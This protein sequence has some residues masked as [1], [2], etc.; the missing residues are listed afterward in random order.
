MLIFIICVSLISVVILAV[1]AWV[2]SFTWNRKPK[3]PDQVAALVTHAKEMPVSHMAHM[4]PQ[5]Q[6]GSVAGIP[7]APSPSDMMMMGGP[8]P[9]PPYRDPGMDMDMQDSKQTPDKV[10]GTR[11][12]GHTSRPLPPIFTPGQTQHN[13]PVY[14]PTPPQ[15]PPS[16]AMGPDNTGGGR[17]PGGRLPPLRGA[18]GGQGRRGSIGSTV[19]DANNARQQRR[20][21]NAS[22][23]Y[24]QQADPLDG[25]AQLVAGSSGANPRGGYGGGG[26]SPAELL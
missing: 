12:A 14:N 15:G 16:G 4:P 7:F 1:G 5:H 26:R 11:Q 24:Q 20:G 10:F 18:Q 22:A 21:S 6:R 3:G 17:K 9:P 2:C 8:P 23:G 13:S 25:V 19:S